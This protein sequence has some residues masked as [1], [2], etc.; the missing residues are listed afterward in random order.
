MLPDIRQR[1]A[2]FED[3]QYY[4]ACPSQKSG[5]R[6]KSRKQHWWS[7]ADKRKP[8]YWEENS[9]QV[10]TCPSKLSQEVV[11]DLTQSPDVRGWRLLTWGKTFLVTWHR[12]TDFGKLITCERTS[13]NIIDFPVPLKLQYVKWSKF[14]CQGLDNCYGSKLMFSIMQLSGFMKR[15]ED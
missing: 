1:I 3:S 4:A 8:K 6:V 10:P 13:F 7:D 5:I 14:T 15:T 9:A 12:L 11:G 2:L